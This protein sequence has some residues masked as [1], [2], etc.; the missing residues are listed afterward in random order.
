MFVALIAVDIEGWIWL[1]DVIA[2]VDADPHLRPMWLN[3]S[4]AL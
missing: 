1:V 4:I 3:A 2:H